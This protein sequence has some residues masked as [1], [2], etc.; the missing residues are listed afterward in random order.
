M[1]AV[2]TG[3]LKSI[4]L[5]S[6]L[7]DLRDL[8]VLIVGEAL[9]LGRGASDLRGIC[10]SLLRGWGFS[11]SPWPGPG[12]TWHTADLNVA[13]SIKWAL[14]ARWL[15]ATILLCDIKLVLSLF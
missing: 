8:R 13:S 6:N 4:E 11:L 12:R 9:V 14:L 2:S 1:L 5:T 7:C 3:L 15:E 10:F